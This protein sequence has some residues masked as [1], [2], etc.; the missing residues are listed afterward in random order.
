MVLARLLV[1]VS[2]YYVIGAA[3]GQGYLVMD[4]TAN[5]SC[6]AMPQNQICPA[7]KHKIVGDHTNPTALTRLGLQEVKL[8]LA[9]AHFFNDTKANDTKACLKYVR[10]YACSN[11]LMKCTKSK[12]TGY[13]FMLKYNI[14]RTK[15]A[16]AKVKRF[17]SSNVLHAVTHNCSVINTDPFEFA[18]CNKHTVVPGD[19]CPT[20]DYT[21]NYFL[22]LTLANSLFSNS[23]LP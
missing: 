12:H 4:T 19:L 18:L 15:K 9:V 3:T 7:F 16:C 17:C 5:A 8:K 21:V 6:H 14:R 11:T 23:P 10:E 2:L 20:T 22:L 13:G 1:F